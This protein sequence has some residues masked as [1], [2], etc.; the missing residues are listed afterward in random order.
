V[1]KSRE[2][3]SKK[4]FSVPVS[5]GDYYFRSHFASARTSPMTARVLTVHFL[6]DYAGKLK[7]VSVEKWDD[8]P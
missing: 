6:F 8:G 3:I 5:G 1:S 4:G 7:D 2:L